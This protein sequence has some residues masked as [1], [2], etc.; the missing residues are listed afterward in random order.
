MKVFFKRLT[1]LFFLLFFWNSTKLLSEEQKAYLDDRPNSKSEILDVHT[2]EKNFSDELFELFLSFLALIALLLLLMLAARK[3][4]QKNIEVLNEKSRIKIIDK[5]AL[6]PKSML[7]LLDIDG[8]SFLIGESSQGLVK[9]SSLMLRKSCE[10]KSEDRQSQ[11]KESHDQLKRE[12]K[13]KPH[14]KAT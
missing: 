1:L 3:Y 4:S 12:L 11:E 9:L 13:G 7:Y 6:G 10:N 2:G 14:E 5:R 8:H